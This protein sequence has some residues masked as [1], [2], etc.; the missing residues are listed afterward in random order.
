MSIPDFAANPPAPYP[1]HEL[2]FDWRR[3]VLAALIWIVAAELSQVYAFRNAPMSIFWPPDG[4]ATGLTLAYGPRVLVPIG[5]AILVWDLMRG[6]APGPALLGTATLIVALLVTWALIRR[7]RRLATTRSPITAMVRYHAITVIPAV[8]ILSLIGSWQFTP[9]ADAASAPDIVLVMAVSETL[10]ILLF[11]RL[12]ELSAHALEAALAAPGRIFRI[13][14]LPAS[15]RPLLW[16]LGLMATLVCVRLAGIPDSLWS[17]LSSVRYLMFILIAWMAYQGRPFSVH[18]ATAL[19]AVVLLALTPDNILSDA[20][21]LPDHALLLGS[22]AF[23]GFLASTTMEQRRQIE[24]SLREAAR[25]DPL[26]GWLNEQGL[27]DILARTPRSGCLIGIDMQTLRHTMELIGLLPTHQIEKD[28]SELIRLDLGRAIAFS[29]P[30][31]G[32]FVILLPDESEAYACLPRLDDLLN[33]RY[34]HGEQSVR[35]Q[36]SIGLL[37]LASRP[38]GET[39]ADTL[40]TLMLS[41]QLAAFQQGHALAYTPQVLSPQAGLA[42]T[43]KARRGQ[44]VMLEEL[45]EALRLPPGC[46][47]TPGLWLACQRIQPTRGDA[48]PGVEILL[49]WTLQ[50]GTQQRPDDFLPLAERYGLMPQVDRWVITHTLA[51]VSAHPVDPGELG[52]VSINLSGASVSNPQLFDFI[53]RAIDD[54]GLPPGLF[55]FEITETA[56]IV[57]REPAIALLARLR[58]LG[59]RTSLDDFGTGMA[60]FDYLTSL[61][62]D[63]V[64]IDGSFIRNLRD[65][66][67][68]LSIV[69]A[70]CMVARTLN[71]QT[72]AEFVETPEQCAILNDCGVDYMQGYGIGR[73]VFLVDYLTA[74]GSPHGG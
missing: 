55:C 45:K 53:Q 39:V 13:R 41:C 24:N 33:Q 26:T 59:I 57:Q 64:K 18:L 15:A 42:A 71:L 16:L 68:S 62:L 4:I 72:V 11:A 63:Y 37:P 19:A 23:L 12:S 51:A 74:A 61:P 21:L 30:H 6:M 22:V 35:I 36:A 50:D 52:K 67:V 14:S 58:A 3:A 17:K 43:I 38:A 34:R 28:L 7:E 69:K 1:R 47:V 2:P 48:A 20:W 40:S 27:V 65:D 9:Q 25:H 29:R 56:G 46:P 73:P 54:S 49:R 66:P 5:A 32:F 8:L 31:E 10:G 60:S 44:L 70:V